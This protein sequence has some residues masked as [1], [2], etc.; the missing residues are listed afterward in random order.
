MERAWEPNVTDEPLL[1]I[2]LLG[3]FAATAVDGRRISFPTR[4]SE[5]LLAYLAAAG[6]A[7]VPRNRIAGLLWGGRG[8]EQAR[9]SLR[10]ELSNLKKALGA[11]RADL[12]VADR[13][14]LWLRS[15]LVD[16]DVAAFE[17]AAAQGSRLA[18]ADAAA[19]YG[20][21]F[22]A[23]LEVQAPE[24]DEWATTERARLKTV[25]V[26]V[27]ERASQAAR[28]A[29]D[30]AAARQASERLIALDPF[31]ERGHRLLMRALTDL[32]QRAEA[33]A[34]FGALTDLLKEELGIAPAPETLRLV[35]AL[36]SEEATNLESASRSAG[37]GGKPSTQAALSAFGGRPAVAVVPF[38]SLSLDPDEPYLANGITEDVVAGLAA[39]RWFPII[40]ATSMA[41]YRDKPLEVQTIRTE[42]GARYVICGSVRRSAD[43][44]RVR[45]DLIDAKTGQQLW[46]E[47]FDRPMTDVLTLQDKI[48]E[49]IVA[50]LEPELSRAE[51]R[52]VIVKRPES[53][54]AWEH[55]MRATW[56]KAQGGR[57]YG[58]REAN[59]AAMNHVREAIRLD[60]Y[61]STAHALLAHYLWQA[62]IQAETDDP[63]RCLQEAIAYARKAI[64]LDDGNWLAY[65]ILGLVQIFGLK[66]PDAG[67][68]SVRQG[69]NLNPGASNVHHGLGCAYEYCGHFEEAIGHLLAV[70]E[71]DPRYRNSAAVLA[72]LALCH[73]MLDEPDTAVA[74]A[75]KAMIE[76]PNYNRGRQRLIAA[77]TAAGDIA[78]AKTELSTLLASQPD[79]SEVY[80]RRTYPFKDTRHIAAFLEALKKA[81][82][83]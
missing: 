29:G 40:G 39:W 25:A 64:A 68:Q 20:G 17:K 23:G 14:S 63:E 21:D 58:T 27:L 41:P 70:F 67:L 45:V 82:A 13:I 4:K 78:E 6:S 50:K 52:R 7:P 24:F 61:F 79:F 56:A 53:L 11:G 28:D 35:E 34:H 16:V 75:R 65:C 42:T 22:L 77:L 19:L 76:D 18:P 51:E 69:F 57:G 60:P 10:Q 49:Q 66:E 26:D 55:I 46:S 81:G 59:V 43:H 36:K 8:E 71:L 83:A 33:L 12:I 74:Y 3:G 54:N 32:G 48:T 73:L 38:Q 1:R 62:F 15:R 72:D 9:A 31:N 44:I 30:A 47:R 37:L 2:R 5:A 80:V